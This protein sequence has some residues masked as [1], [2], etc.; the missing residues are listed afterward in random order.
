[1]TK[2]PAEVGLVLF[3]LESRNQRVCADAR[4]HSIAAPYR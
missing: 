2:K 4:I 1:M 3:H